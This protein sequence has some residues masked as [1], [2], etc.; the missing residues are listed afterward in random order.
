MNCAVR[1][2]VGNGKGCTDHFTLINQCI[3]LSLM[4]PE[5]ELR[6]SSHRA[7]VW[8]YMSS[9]IGD[10][11]PTVEYRFLSNDDILWRRIH[12]QAS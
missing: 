12:L 7:A 10:M 5:P 11:S 6:K 3:R 2:N 1:R 9:N 4:V 8:D